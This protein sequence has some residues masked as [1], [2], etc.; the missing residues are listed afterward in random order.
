MKRRTA[1][2][3]L[4]V[5]TVA[6]LAASAWATDIVGSD[7]AGDLKR[8]KGLTTKERQALDIVSVHVVGE[9]GLGVFVTVTFKGNIQQRI[10]RGHLK[11]ALVAL[12]LRP[13]SGDALPAGLVTAGTGPVGKISG[14]TTSEQVAVVREGRRLHFMILGPGFGN[15]ET[16]EVKTFRRTPTRVAQARA[17]ELVPDVPTGVWRDILAGYQSFDGWGSS[18]AL[19]ASL[20]CEQ[21]D[22]LER[23]IKENMLPYLNGLEQE[24]GGAN[25]DKIV[26]RRQQ[27][28]EALRRIA[29][30]KKKRCEPGSGI[31][32]VLSWKPYPGDPNEVIGTGR[33]TYD[34]IVRTAKLRRTAG[35]VAISLDALRVV[36]PGSRTITAYLCP[37]QLPTG[38]LSQTN[39]PA[40]TLTCTGGT[41]Q[42]GQQFTLNVRMTP[43]PTAGMGGQLYGRPT[44][45]EFQ[46]PFQIT[47]P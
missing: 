38:S 7:P 36:I 3:A 5:A 21:L 30:L 42:T 20:S 45:G 37:S 17:G 2:V 43:A 35:A 40:D 41:L 26:E 25:K 31:D 47:G 8:A 34:V 22:S 15:V 33:F 32:A 39:R 28:T 1:V 9:E 11:D 12:I 27:Y 29:E 13:K 24:A 19:L 23:T 46:G 10:G 18:A 4:A 14:R 6:L 44:G 16:V